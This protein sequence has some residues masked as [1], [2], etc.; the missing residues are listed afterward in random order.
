MNI[1]VVIVALLSF[2]FFI[3]SGGGFGFR[4][5]LLP[6]I[7]LL[8]IYKFIE[9]LNNYR[10]NETFDF[11]IFVF[12]LSFLSF[13]IYALFISTVNNIEIN[14]ILTWILPILFFFFLFLALDNFIAKDV[15]HGYVLSGVLFCIVINIVFFTALFLP[16]PQ[17]KLFLEGF[18][19]IPGWFYLRSGGIWPNY[20]NI[21][22]QATL[23]L[24]PVA[25]LAYRFN[26]FRSFFFILF[27]LSICLSRFGVLILI[28]YSVYNFF[29]K[30]ESFKNKNKFA[31]HTFLYFNLL[32]GVSVLSAL[33]ATYILT[34]D[35]Y[36]HSFDSLNIRVGHLISIFKEQDL[37]MFLFG[38]GA[39]SHFFSLGSQASIDNIEIS[40]LEVLRKYGLSGFILLHLAFFNLNYYFIKNDCVDLSYIFIAYYLVCLSNPLL[41]TFNLSWLM[42]LLIIVCMEKKKIHDK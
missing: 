11:R 22:F 4:L 12:Y 42:C 30:F 37:N 19:S 34:G 32:I 28:C 1:K 24:V 18:S 20:P 16:L 13:I 17:S 39:G 6:L 36:I 14:V 9:I 35:Y 38:S 40:Q 31:S 23:G 27:T 5:F 41:L 15:V 10:A 25:L 3:D 26:Y 21:Y 8:S 29:F 2:V 33:I 7:A